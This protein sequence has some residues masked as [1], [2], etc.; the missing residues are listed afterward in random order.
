MKWTPLQAKWVALLGLVCAIDAEPAAANQSQIV[1]AP[2]LEG[3]VVDGDI[4]DWP[5]SMKRYTFDHSEHAS[6][7]REGAY[8]MTGHS[9]DDGKLYLAIVVEDNQVVRGRTWYNTDGVEVYL[10]RPGIGQSNPTQYAMIPGSS[11]RGD[12]SEGHGSRW[13]NTG[14]DGDYR[15]RDGVIT[16]EWAFELSDLH[17]R[18]PAA[19]TPGEQLGFDV[20]ILDQPVGGRHRWIPWGSPDVG[21]MG[22]N[23]RVG[24]LTLTSNVAN[25]HESSVWSWL[26]TISLWLLP[27]AALVAAG[28]VTLRHYLP[29]S[30][31]L[32]AME[33]RLTDTQDVMIAL[34]DK[35]DRLEKHILPSSEEDAS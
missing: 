14:T 29:Q 4:S 16:Y 8:F 19:L 6:Q 22:S 1:R 25:R 20:V 3:I 34:S 9:Q 10:S 33:Q 26:G 28:T 5:S 32:E 21:K 2:I 31:R 24:R 15:Y 13:R 35:I 12:L 11:G 27:L 17:T 23:S 30:R 18:G 7:H